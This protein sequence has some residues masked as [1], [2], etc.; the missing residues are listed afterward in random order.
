MGRFESL[1]PTSFSAHSPG[2]T[3]TILVLEDEMVLAMHLEDLILDIPGASATLVASL[4]EAMAAA[5]TG[6]F[7]AAILDVNLGGRHSF[8]VA[9]LLKARS[10]PYAFVTG[11]GNRLIPPEHA[12]APIVEK[13]FTA[14]QISGVIASMSG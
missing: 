2:S 3:T 12:E 8:P 13:P 4:E 1:A 6:N 7:R 10:I 5:E 14:E 11:Y 9:D